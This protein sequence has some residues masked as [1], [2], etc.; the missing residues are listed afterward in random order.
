MPFSTLLADD[1][2]VVR[3]GIRASLEVGDAFAIC[4][5][6]ADGIEAVQLAERLQPD[7]LILDL[8]MPGLNGMDSLRIIRHRSPNTR[9]IF[10]SIYPTE[11]YVAEAFQCGALGY[12]LKGGRISE[13]AD[14]LH[15]ALAGR[16]YLSPPISAQRIEGYLAQAQSVGPN[17][18]ELL[19]P[20][21]RQVLQLA[22]EGKT[23]RDI[24]VR[25][26]ISERT[27]ERHR[28]NL[29][30]KLGLRTQTELVLY[31]LNHGV[32]AKTNHS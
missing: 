20:R 9:V 3:Q 13:I 22:A 25:L 4:G 12:V 1:H 16:R 24:G 7:L 10:L 5:E 6:A 15:E 11:S 32:P 14:A 31:A 27:V 29:L 30:H 2:A 18:H 19:T 26:F 21:E 23:C 17:S 28:A 8:M